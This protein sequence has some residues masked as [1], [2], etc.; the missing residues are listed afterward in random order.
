MTNPA[1]K[2]ATATIAA[3]T[4]GATIAL[5]AAPAEAKFGRKGALFGGIAAGLVGAAIIGSAAHA[6][7]GYYEGGECWREKRPV[8]NSWGEFRGYRYSRVCN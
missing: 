8:Y 4:I 6:H 1:K 2:F 7:G 5:S 3:L